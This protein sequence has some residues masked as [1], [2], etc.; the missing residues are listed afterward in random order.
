VNNSAGPVSIT[1]PPANVEGKRIVLY[2]Q[3]VQ[4]GNTA[5]GGEPG[6]CGSSTESTQLTLQ[7]QG[8]DQI[9]GKNNVLGT[10]ASFFRYAEVISH[11]GI[12][13]VTADR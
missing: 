8:T 7:R 6:N 1:L 12:W 5:G 9:Y 4:C 2:V 13:Y 11:S 3:F 10:S